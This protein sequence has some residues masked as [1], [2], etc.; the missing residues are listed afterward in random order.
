MRQARATNGGTDLEGID[1][2]FDSPAPVGDS[3]GQRWYY[4][5]VR[6][7]LPSSVVCCV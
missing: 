3:K 5:E 6:S 1:G 7:A 4:F 2:S